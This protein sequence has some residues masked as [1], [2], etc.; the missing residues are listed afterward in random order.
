MAKWL[1]LIP[2]PILAV[3]LLGV[4]DALYKVG[5]TLLIF[6]GVVVVLGV[7]VF[8]TL[9][10]FPAPSAKSGHYRNKHMP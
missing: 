6:L 2:V 5:P 4:W 1:V 7:V 10:L 8:V 9:L 3:M